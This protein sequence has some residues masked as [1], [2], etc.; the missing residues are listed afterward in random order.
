M[1]A[2]IA[3]ALAVVGA[4]FFLLDLLSQYVGRRH[5]P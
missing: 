4:G 5:K 1:I 3:V 2:Y